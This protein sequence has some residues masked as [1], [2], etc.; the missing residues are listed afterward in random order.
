MEPR[1]CVIQR[2]PKNNLQREDSVSDAKPYSVSRG[3]VWEAWKR[4]QANQGAAGV[5]DESI[6]DFEKDL[7]DNLI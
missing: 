4:V 1:G 6:H 7:K 2:Y 5:D 3:L